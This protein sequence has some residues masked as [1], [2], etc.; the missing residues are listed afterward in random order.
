M[1]QTN[2]RAVNSDTEKWYDTKF[3]IKV[4]VKYWILKNKWDIYLN[5]KT[6][7]M[8]EKLSITNPL[9]STSE[10]NYQSQINEQ[11]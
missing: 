4:L 6:S 11:N 1:Y 5:K 2:Y 8:G 10:L 3:T 7:I 9:T